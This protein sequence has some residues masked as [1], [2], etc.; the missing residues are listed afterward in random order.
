MIAILINGESV[1][2]DGVPVQT[3]LLD[4]LRDRGLT[5]AKEGCAEGECGACTVAMVANSESGSAYRAVNSCLMFVPSAIGRE[6]YTVEALARN[7]ELS[8]PQSAMAA[9]GG[10][11]CG[12]CT[13]GFVMSLFTEQYRPGRTGPCDPHALSGNLCRCTGYRPIRDAALSLGPAPE[14]AFLDRLTQPALALEAV[15]YK[16]FDRPTSLQ[17]CLE[18][19]S[20][21]REAKWISGAT[22]I[23]VESNLRFRRWSHL[24][25]VEAVPELREFEDTPDHVHI[26]A[27]LPLQE[28]EARWTSAPATIKDWLRFFASPPI[29]NPRH[30]GRQ[31]GD[32]FAHRRCGASAHGT[33]RFRDHQQHSRRSNGSTIL[34]L[35]ELPGNATRCRR[36][37][38]QHRNSQAVPPIHAIL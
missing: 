16:G 33:Q 18:L 30:S 19:A 34:V 5:G 21:D 25:S 13:P 36:T 12:Y 29:R 15:A 17:A 22:D 24:I 20:R 14:G 27:A 23:A 1:P 8:E 6:F 2:V 37:D 28:L 38:S 26:G 11:Q 10:S 9:A 7:G 31:S 4:F 32:G 35:P 3:T